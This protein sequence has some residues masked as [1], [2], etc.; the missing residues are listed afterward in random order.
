MMSLPSREALTIGYFFSA[1]TAAFTKK[2]INP[3]RTPCAFSNFSL[4]FARRSMTG[5]ILT[6]L[7]VVRIA[8]V[9]CDS[10]KRSAMRARKRDIGTRCSGRSVFHLSV[11]SGALTAGNADGGAAGAAMSAFVLSSVAARAFFSD[12][13]CV[14]SPFCVFGIAAGSPPSLRDGDL[15]CPH[16]SPYCLRVRSLGKLTENALAH[17]LWSSVRRVRCLVIGTYQ[18]PFH[19]SVLRLRASQPE[20]GCCVS[21]ARRSIS[22]WPVQSRRVFLP[23]PPHRPPSSSTA[24]KWLQK[25]IQKVAEPSHLPLPLTSAF[26][27]R[28]RSDC[29]A[30]GASASG[31]VAAQFENALIRLLL[32]KC[33]T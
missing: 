31:S 5:C 22:R 8:F 26:I 1:Y 3:R 14:A 30:T 16:R 11:S 19:R 10:S 23:P 18:R 4:Y 21:P 6:S 12:F 25:R 7:K 33:F 24:A 2:D 27:S 13:P 29:V 9:R 28:A 17:P 32:K 20:C 15:L